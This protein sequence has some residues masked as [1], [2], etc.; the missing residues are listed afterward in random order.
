VDRGEHI[1]YMVLEL[2]VRVE[3]SDGIEVGRVKRVLQVPEKD[4][5]DG[6]VVATRDGERFADADDVGE[7]YERVV[8]LRVTADEAARLPYPG[9][10]PAT[11][12]VTPDDTSRG[13]VGYTARRLWSR[14]TGS[15]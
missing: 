12:S 4:V 9:A 5:F 10:N 3:S 8:I 2:G 11:M 13:G 1:S 7:I 6:I 14:I 15:R